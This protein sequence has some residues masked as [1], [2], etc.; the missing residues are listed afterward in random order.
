MKTA[1]LLALILAATLLPVM[2]QQDPFIEQLTSDPNM[3]KEL[4]GTSATEPYFVKHEDKL[5][6]ELDSLIHAFAK[7]KHGADSRLE[8]DFIRQKNWAFFMGNLVDEKGNP[9][10][11]KDEFSSDAA[12]LLLRTVNGWQIVD[13]SIGHSDAFYLIWPTQYGISA[14][15]FETGC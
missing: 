9:V 11:P 3:R 15:M 10:T 8:G 6:Q 4:F 2:A 1:P 7:K 5:H 13:G 12:F 14:E